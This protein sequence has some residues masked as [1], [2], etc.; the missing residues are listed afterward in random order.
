VAAFY[1]VPKTYCPG[2]WDPP[3]C[4]GSCAFF[5]AIVDGLSTVVGGLAEVWDVVAS[6][7]NGIVTLAIEIA[8]Q[9]N[10]FCL[11]ARVA[12]AVVDWAVDEDIGEEA[13]DV[14][15]SIARVA[16]RAVVSA[17]M[18][19]FGLPPTLPT[20]DQL[21]AIAEGDL[22]TLAVEY[23]KTLGVPCDEMKLSPAE[24]ELVVGGVEA[25][26]GDVPIDPS[27]GVDLCGQMIGAVIG[28]VKKTVATALQG[29]IA[30]STGLPMPTTYEPGFEAILEPRAH[31][32]GAVVRLDATPSI[33]PPVGFSCTFHASATAGERVTGSFEYRES[34][35]LRNGS[36]A[37]TFRVALPSFDVGYNGTV[38]LGDGSELY[39]GNVV[40]PTITADKRCL[41]TVPGVAAQPVKPPLGRW[42]PGELN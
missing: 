17:V 1:R 15:T 3:P 12:G 33:E 40:T 32:S 26:G 22:T 16:T 42:A 2:D 34:L 4:T 5:E 39:E 31:Y 21:L 13:V 6:V 41:P 19:S 30:A 27:G 28:E 38:H 37:V 10:P 11:Q 18:V 8:A 7:Y 23:L 36:A 25:A 20:S 14:C 35:Y 29:Q 9:L 24:A